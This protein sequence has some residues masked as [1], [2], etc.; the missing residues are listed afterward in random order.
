MGR[1]GSVSLL[2]KEEPRSN[3]R[4]DNAS[5]TCNR[6]R[7]TGRNRPS[8]LARGRH[9]IE[10]P[11]ACEIVELREFNC[12]LRNLLSKRLLTEQKSKV[13]LLDRVGFAFQISLD[14]FVAGKKFFV[15]AHG[16]RFPASPRPAMS[17]EESGGSLCSQGGAIPSLANC[18]PTPKRGTFGTINDTPCR[19]ERAPTG[20]PYAS[21][22]ERGAAA[23]QSTER[24]RLSQHS[25][26]IR[27][28]T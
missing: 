24:I 22:K 19:G 14:Q 21:Y 6:H 16:G 5:G 10:K 26:T 9:D 28:G 11:L 7:S 8:A 12:I 4:N 25:G 27:K 20:V 18:P 23:F 3:E 17:V 2:R 15:T 13:L 1:L